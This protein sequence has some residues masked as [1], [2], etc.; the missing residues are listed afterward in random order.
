MGAEEAEPV[1][2][3][4]EF[5]V[6]TTGATTTAA[7]ETSKA[8]EDAAE[9]AT[10][11]AEDSEETATEVAEDTKMKNEDLQVIGE[12]ATVEGHPTTDGRMKTEIGED[13]KKAKIREV[14]TTA[15]VVL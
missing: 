3:A 1:S 12:E 7:A 8:L 4:K 11:A 15:S 5:P 14:M 10:E 6:A 9:T 13:L 2:A